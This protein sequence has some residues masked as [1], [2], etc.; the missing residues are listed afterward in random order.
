M[1][2][3]F[4]AAIKFCLGVYF[5]L[6]V[7]TVIYVGVDVLTHDFLLDTQSLVGAQ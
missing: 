5:I 6:L 3:L 2:N 7:F 4:S 1:N